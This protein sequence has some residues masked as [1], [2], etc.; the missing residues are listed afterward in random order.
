MGQGGY[1]TLSNETD[2]DWTRT[3]QH[4]YQM[5]WEFPEA[6]PAGTSEKIYV[7]W[8]QGV[9][10]TETDDAAEAQYVLDGTDIGFEVQARAKDG[11]KLQ[12]LPM[13]VPG[14]PSD[15]LVDVGWEHNGVVWFVM[16]GTA[17][18]LRISTKE[19]WA[20]VPLADWMNRLNGTLKLSQLTIPGTHD[21]CARE[22]SKLSETQIQTVGAQ[23]K[24]GIRF[25][26][27]RCRHVGNAFA[28]HHDKEFLNQWFNEV[29]DTCY[30][31]LDKHPRETIVM[32]VKREHTDADNTRSFQATFD[33]Y[34]EKTRSR[35]YLGDRIPSLDEVRGKIVLFRRF[36]A[37]TTPLGI[38]AWSDWVDKGTFVIARNGVTLRVQDKYEVP[39]M[40]DVAKKWDAVSAHLSDAL[41]G[42]SA[43]WYLNYISGGSPFAYPESVAKGTRGFPGMNVRLL[44]HLDGNTRGRYGTLLLDFAESPGLLIRTIVDHNQLTG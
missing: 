7:E 42:A 28:I 13:N 8:D 39:T 4:S 24:L 19:K 31:F 26:D 41:R 43:D 34:I 12:V 30:A 17:D 16:A 33:S 44:G 6:I 1:I 14:R 25:L 5:A 20:D 15:K 11:F 3:Y 40:L 22:C 36:P 21:S 37:D 18:G 35:W 27:I 2:R 10:K 9:F 38:D 23:L 29:R 32:L